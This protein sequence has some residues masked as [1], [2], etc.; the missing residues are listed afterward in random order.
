MHEIGKR[1]NEESFLLLYKA[2]VLK[3]N[4]ESQSVI[5]KLPFT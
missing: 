5:E 4:P 1:L 2:D 3:Y